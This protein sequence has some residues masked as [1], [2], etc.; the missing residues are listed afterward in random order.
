M[1]LKAEN[2]VAGAIPVLLMAPG[3]QPQQLP[4]GQERS[5]VRLVVAREK[6]SRSAK[7]QQLPDAGQDG[8]RAGLCRARQQ[9]TRQRVTEILALWR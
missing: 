2:S 7:T 6:R 4:G 5:G 3:G 8:H 9:E 1:T